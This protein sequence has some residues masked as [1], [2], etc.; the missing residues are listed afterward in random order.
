MGFILSGGMV[1]SGKG[2]SRADVF[3]QNGIVSEIAPSI[4]YSHHK[5]TLLN[6]LYI[7]PG[8]V[9]VHV[10]LREPG[11]SYKETIKSGTLAAARAGYTAVCA[12]PN[13]NPPPDSPE[14]LR[15]QTDII[16][17]DAVI[18]VFPYATITRGQAGQELVDFEVM[19][20][21]A[22]AF[23]DDGIGVQS[24]AVMER[25]MIRAKEQNC[26][27]AAHC[28]D[29]SLLHG[30]YIHDGR[31]AKKHGHKGLSS[32]SEYKQ[33][34]RD[35]ALAKKTGCRYNICHVSTKESVEL[36]RRA[37]SEGVKVTAETAPHYL[38]LCE[39]DLREEGRFKMNPPLRSKEDKAA[40]TEGIKDGTIDIIATDH[41]P[42]SKEEK[43]KGLAG[44]LMGVAGLET[45]FPVLYTGLVKAGII[46]LEKLIEL[47]CVNPRRYF[48]IS[49]GLE[50][51]ADADIAVLDLENGYRI[52]SEE[53]LSCG[54]SSPFDGMEVYGNNIITYCKGKRVW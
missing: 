32:A 9:D 7:I 53:F 21:K 17:K 18:K 46:T 29:N 14:N 26:I 52:N 1:Y 4:S 36:I 54:K 33:V 37:K 44:S 40:L 35:L 30:G 49:G 16:E 22:V 24:S 42:H 43:A 50:I 41:A 39:D 2:F 11:F 3:I 13:L 19:R 28:E 34:E 51:G 20:D 6:N 27:I 48:G 5:K 10:H 15:V 38:L 25:A 47:M 23:S 8:F 45:A 31:Y 12:M